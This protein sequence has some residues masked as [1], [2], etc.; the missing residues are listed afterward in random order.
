MTDTIRDAFN[1]ANPN[2]LPDLFRSIGVGDLLVGQLPQV[3]RGASMVANGVSGYN[4]ATLHA[5]APE[6]H[7]AGASIQ[8][9][10][11]RAGGVTGELTVVAY[12]ATPATTQIAVAPNGSIVT[13][14]ADAITDIDINYTPERGDVIEAVISVTSNDIVLSSILNGKK[15]ILL[16]EAEV[17]VGTSTGKKIVLVPGGVPAAG[18]ANLDVPKGTIHFAVAD[19]ATR[20]RIKLLVSATND[21]TTVMNGVDTVM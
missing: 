4:V 10:T 14:A 18:R 6:G 19:A 1:R 9:A 12:G 5:Y 3:V 15:A 13:L 8:R 7:S 17:L 2:T 16:L 11:V 20:A 21:L